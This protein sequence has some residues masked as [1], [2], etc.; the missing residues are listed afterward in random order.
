MRTLKG[1]AAL[2][3][4]STSGIGLSIAKALATNGA[5]LMLNGFGDAGDIENLRRDLSDTHGVNVLY[6]PADMRNPDEIETMVRDAEAAFGQIDV[7]VNN[8]GIQHVAPVDEF[9]VDKW[10]DIIAINMSS[11]FHTIR[12]ALPK[13]K[14]HGWGRIVNV[15][16]IHGLTASPFKSAY[17]TAK[18][19]VIGLTRTVALEVAEL[20]ITV[21]AICPGY[22]KTPLVENQ[23]ADTAKLRGIPE[24]DVIRN[25]LLERQPTKQFVEVDEVAALTVFLCSDGARSITGIALPQDGGWSAL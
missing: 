17:V 4:G 7:L 9:P 10:N 19:G 25:V 14:A 5:N 11:N 24:D 2:V 15:A 13:M 18:H 23:I 21:N 22:V 8:A 1:K 3:T 6:S 16:S 12:A 20:G